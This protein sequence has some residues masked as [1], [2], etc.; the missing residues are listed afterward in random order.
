MVVLIVDVDD[1]IHPNLVPWEFWVFEEN[2]EFY[3]KSQKHSRKQI[4][5]ISKKYSLVFCIVYCITYSFSLTSRSY[6]WWLSWLLMLIVIW[7]PISWD[8]S[9]EMSKIIVSSTKNTSQQKRFLD[10]L[11]P[12]IQKLFSSFCLVYSI[13]YFFLL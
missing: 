9:L 5:W 3:K 10:C 4:S 13:R 6:T 12:E 8:E 7:I 1:N 11:N 2:I